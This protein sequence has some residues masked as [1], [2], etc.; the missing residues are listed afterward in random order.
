MMIMGGV[1]TGAQVYG[2]R[3]ANKSS[4]KAFKSQQE[5]EKYSLDQQLELERNREAEER[6]RYEQERQDATAQRER[7]EAAQKP[8][9]SMRMA[10]MAALAKK[11]G[12][13]MPPEF[14]ASLMG[15]G[16][17]MG[18]SQPSAAPASVQPGQIGG[19]APANMLQMG[20]PPQ[21]Q[22]SAMPQ[23]RKPLTAAPQ[24]QQPNPQQP[25]NMLQMMQMLQAQG[26][27]SP[28][29]PQNFMGR[30]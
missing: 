15:G 1:T 3:S 25:T 12:L 20:Q 5:A 10:A 26:Q 14:F 23:A 27:G 11:N 24:F 4:E 6:R 7:D 18:G 9:N 28:Q 2:Q 16:G 22:P 8:F 30:Y 21:A 29:M 19:S 17:A 13:N